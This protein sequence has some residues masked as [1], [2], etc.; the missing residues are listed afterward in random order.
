MSSA[1]ALLTHM[2]SHHFQ[3]PPRQENVLH[4][5]E[6]ASILSVLACC[7]QQPTSTCDFHIR[8]QK[9]AREQTN[10][11]QRVR[12][13]RAVVTALQVMV[14]HLVND[15]P[16]Q[17]VIQCPFLFFLPVA[18]SH[19]LYSLMRP[20]RSTVGGQRSASLSINPEDKWQS[21]ES[22]WKTGRL[23][24]RWSPNQRGKTQTWWMSILWRSQSRVKLLF[25]LHKQMVLVFFSRHISEN[26][27][28]PPTI[29]PSVRIFRNML[30]RAR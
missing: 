3:A 12:H 11:L 15:E 18:E 9:V 8:M 16:Q 2:I 23:K 14:L 7:C 19:I 1:V 10:T 13:W 30:R 26:M 20:D 29:S 4:Q 27:S 25:Q 22:W 24:H 21:S 6:S 5:S 28:D 17:K